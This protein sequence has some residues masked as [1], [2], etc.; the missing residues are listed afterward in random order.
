SASSL[1]SLST[2]ATIPTTSSTSS[3]TSVIPPLLTSSDPLTS[4][5]STTTGLSDTTT[6]SSIT[7]TIPV[8]ATVSSTSTLTTPTTPTTTSPSTSTTVVAGG[9]T[10]V[11]FIVVALTIFLL[12]ARRAKQFDREV[13]AAAAAPAPHSLDDDDDTYRQPADQPTP[14]RLTRSSMR[15]LGPA[16]GEL[17]NNPYATGGAAGVGVARARSTRD[18]GAFASGFQDGAT[19]YPAFLGPAAFQSGAYGVG[20][21]HDSFG[22]GVGAGVG[23]GM[24]R[25]MS[26]K[27]HPNVDYAIGLAVP[28]G[29]APWAVRPAVG[30]CAESVTGYI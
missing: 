24:Q 5:T 30:P 2:A 18:P 23:A 25:G 15:D 29:L 28:A 9:P 12:V 8:I 20:A 17:Y 19:P 10:V 11:G 3:T 14:S 13:E 26:L 6:S 4:T 27:H 16:P 22:A 21:G 7:D 1:S